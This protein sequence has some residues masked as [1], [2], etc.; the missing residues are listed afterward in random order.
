MDEQS[1]TTPASFDP[2]DPLS[3]RIVLETAEMSLAEFLI[4]C[5]DSNDE[6]IPLEL[7]S[8][9]LSS[10]RGV[11]LEAGVRA[12]EIGADSANWIQFGLEFKPGRV[13]SDLY[14]R[15]ASLAREM[16]QDA[17]ISNF[18][19]MHKPP[20]IRLRFETN[21]ARRHRLAD[22][23]RHRLEVWQREGLVERI[24]PGVY[25]PETHLFGGPVSMRS[26]HELFTIDSLA[27]LDFHA[28][29]DSQREASVPA[30]ALSLAMLR[31]LFTGLGITDWEDLDVWDR[32]RRKTGRSL[33]DEALPQ[34]EFEEAASGIQAR[35]LNSQLLLKELSPQ[36]R[37]IAENYREAVIGVTA[38]W[39]SG[40]FASYDAHVGPRAGAALFTIFHWNRSALPLTRQAL[41]AEALVARRTV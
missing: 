27:W 10:F 23:L 11:F 12:L 34:A 7:R 31:A 39:C 41:L 2:A 40:Y 18:F 13:C 3:Y 8:K 33:P 38:R 1:V 17:S 36:V 5:V 32:V 29:A 30:W 4:Y 37:S 22:D 6:R 28:L 35:W 24:V 25:E 16:L 9:D 21:A 26:V 19:F 20:G 14:R 15:A